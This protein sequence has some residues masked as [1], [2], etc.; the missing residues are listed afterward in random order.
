MGTVS[1]SLSGR[2]DLGDF[3][4][5]LEDEEEG[6]GVFRGKKDRFGDVNVDAKGQERCGENGE[7]RVSS[8]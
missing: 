7:K 3:N 2:T 6:T 1:P 4:N 8:C 5:T